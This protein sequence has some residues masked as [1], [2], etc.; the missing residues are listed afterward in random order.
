MIVSLLPSVEPASMIMCSY[1]ENDCELTLSNVLSKPRLLLK[2]T[3]IILSIGP[4]IYVRFYIV[5]MIVWLFGKP[6]LFSG[7]LFPMNIVL[8]VRYLNG[9]IENVFLHYILLL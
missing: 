5:F 1:D 9:L 8:N 3:V 6:L 2:F 7:L 4:F